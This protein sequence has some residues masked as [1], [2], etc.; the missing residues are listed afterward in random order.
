M[1]SLTGAA[2][3]ITSGLPESIEFVAAAV[4]QN[5]PNAAADYGCMT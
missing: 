5:I 1:V 2:H 4:E 3:G